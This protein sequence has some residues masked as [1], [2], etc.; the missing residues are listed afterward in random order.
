MVPIALESFRPLMHRPDGFSIGAVEPVPSVAPHPHQANLPQHAK[1]LRHRR[2]VD[3]D[4]R[5]NFAHLPFLN[6]EQAENLPATRLGHGIESVG[7]GSSPSHAGTIY[8]YIGICQ[9][10]ACGKLQLVFFEDKP[11]P[12]RCLER[13]GVL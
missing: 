13:G 2:L 10:Y 12:T 8:S 1:M 7:G 11:R 9:V 4:G 6:D 5:N 3:A